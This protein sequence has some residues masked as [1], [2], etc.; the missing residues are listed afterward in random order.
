MDRKEKLDILFKAILCSLILVFYP[1]FY[2]FKGGIISFINVFGYP[3]EILDGILFYVI[4]LIGVAGNLI[5]F[6][7]LI[8]FFKECFK[9]KNKM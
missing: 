4:N 5:L 7:C 2:M 1:G 6:Y 9:F 8:L 3:N